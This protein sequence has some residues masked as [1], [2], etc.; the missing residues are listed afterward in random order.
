MLLLE[1]GLYAASREDTLMV[2]LLKSFLLLIHQ[3]ENPMD[4]SWVGQDKGE[5]VGPSIVFWH[6][7]GHDGMR[8]EAHAR[9]NEQVSHG[10]RANAVRYL[11]SVPDGGGISLTTIQPCWV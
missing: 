3:R 7:E 11:D 2:G 9:M 6:F 10:L 1:L 8:H 4:F 5:P